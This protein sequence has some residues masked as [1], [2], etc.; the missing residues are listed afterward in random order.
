VLDVTV[1]HTEESIDGCYTCLLVG[2]AVAVSDDDVVDRG[3]SDCL[4]STHL[5]SGA[6]LLTSCRTYDICTV[7]TLTYL[8]IIVL[9]RLSRSAGEFEVGLKCLRCSHKSGH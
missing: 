3:H 2:S 1:Q 5:L 7:S 6:L 9:I 4:G 8:I